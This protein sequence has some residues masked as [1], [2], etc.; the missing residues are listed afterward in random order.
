MLYD[1]G[2]KPE[3]IVD[4]LEKDLAEIDLPVNA[5]EESVEIET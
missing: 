2:V 5:V 1:Y 3:A 4:K